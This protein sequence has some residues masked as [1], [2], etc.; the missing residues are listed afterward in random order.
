MLSTAPIIVQPLGLGTRLHYWE[1]SLGYELRGVIDISP[2][3]F[4]PYSGIDESKILTISL[5][6]GCEGTVG[7]PLV[8][9]QRV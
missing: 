9:L 3:C 4:S 5:E 8:K 2:V 7:G 1:P 6:Y